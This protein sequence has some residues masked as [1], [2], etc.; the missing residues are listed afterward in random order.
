MHTLSSMAKRAR[1]ERREAA[2]EAEKLARARMKLALL[3]AGGAPER[4]IVVA[5]AS[6]VE[7]HATSLP[8]PAC[9]VGG[10][11]L[12]EHAAEEGLR[13]TRVRCARCGTRREIWFR[14]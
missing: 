3:E 8:C 6:V 12:D 13:V 10:V 9:G 5:S 2:R 11:R 1:T 4:P 14:I 7:P